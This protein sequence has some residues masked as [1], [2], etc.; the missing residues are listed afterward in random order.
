MENQKCNKEHPQV[1]VVMV[2]LPAQGH[3]NQLLHLSH[4]ITTYGIP[5]HFA[6]S[7]THNRQAKLRLQG[8]DTETLTKIHFHDFELP[9]YDSTSPKIDLSCPFPQHLLPLFE[10]STHLRDPVSQ[11]LQ[12]LS[13]KFDR[14]VV[15]HDVIMAY[16]VQD[17]K[18]LPNAE[19]YTFNPISAFTTFL[20]T[21]ETIP[22]NYKLHFQLQ[23]S[24]TDIIPKDI[25]TDAYRCMS[26]EM[27]EFAMNQFK[28][29]GFKSGWLYNTSRVI[30]GRYLQLLE[31]IHSTK[32]ET[33]HFALGPF[34][35]VVIESAENRH[36]SFKWLDEQEKDS[37][38][39]V[40]FGST[41]SLRGDQI[42]ELAKGLEESGEKFI[43]VLRGADPN[44]VFAQGDQVTRPHLQQGYEERVKDRGIV[45]RDW[46]PQLEILAHPSVGGFMS[47]C[48]WN[49]CMESISMGVPIAA[50]PMH[51]DQPRNAILISEVLRIGMVVKDWARRSELVTSSTI[52]NVVKALM[53]SEEG[54][55]MKERAAKLGEGVRES[56]AQGGVASLERDDFIAY[57]TR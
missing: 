54:K 1:V 43:W 23:H 29:L 32:E 24:T 15:I 3:L 8:W 42:E 21:W 44:D 18:L 37:V 14:V 16:V 25:L 13:G 51:S 27:L 52:A 9:P 57:I 2:P 10:A 19:A 47:H 30:E 11:L 26:K 36:H 38:I 48:G 39:Y 40:S 12:Q 46:A 56:V 53:A 34:S 7:S 22:E 33:K 55:E 49:S 20:Q 50:W 5:V 35:P 4:L 6:G 28:L 31:T 17:V 45:L 41:V